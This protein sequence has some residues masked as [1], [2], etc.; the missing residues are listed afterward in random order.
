MNVPTPDV[1][2]SDATGLDVTGTVT[3]STDVS[4]RRSSRTGRTVATAVSVL[5][6][7]AVLAGCGS[8]DGGNSDGGSG[9]APSMS[10]A[11]S[12]GAG[13]TSGRS[14]TGTAGTNPQEGDDAAGAQDISRAKAS[15]IA[16]E[17]YGGSAVSVEREDADGQPVWEVELEGS[18][19]GRI[20]V[21]VARSGGGIIGVEHG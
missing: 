4:G 18:S 16:T 17:E 5:A 6:G 11:P 3:R 8:G 21:N 9:V 1:T 15:M 13:P 2:G 20:E 14:S 19:E 7:A 10:T 12:D